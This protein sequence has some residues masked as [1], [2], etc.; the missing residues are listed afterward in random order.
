MSLDSGRALQALGAPRR[1][2]ILELTA[3]EELSAGAISKRFAEVS[4]PAVSQH[5]RVLKEA[6][7]LIERRHGTRRLY[8]ADTQALQALC[9]YL[10]DMRASSQRL[11]HRLRL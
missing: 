2:A 11:D 4:A 7:L 6:G 9:D 8:R 10:D 5:L 3:A 1:R